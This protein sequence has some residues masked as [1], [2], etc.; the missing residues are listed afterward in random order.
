MSKR[1]V[2][3]RVP[4]AILYSD[5]LIKIEGVRLSYPHLDEPYAGDDGGEP[6]FGAVGLLPKATHKEAQKLILEEIN[7]LC[8]EKKWMKDGKRTIGADR[9]F[10][11]DGDST[12]KA[13]N[14]GMWTVSA[15]EKVAPMLRDRANRTVQQKDAARVF[16]GGCWAN[17]VIRPWSQDNKYGKR[18][19]ANLSMVQFV[20]D[21]TAFGEGRLSEDDADDI[22]GSV[23]DADDGLGGD[24]GDLDDL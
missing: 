7:K 17:L 22:L 21:D 24:D 16:Y 4:N 3:K 19:N 11:K 13:E 9:L 18:I 5:G 15:R 6:K 10:L 2:V 20:K 1:S 12:G 23:E 14:E 8:V